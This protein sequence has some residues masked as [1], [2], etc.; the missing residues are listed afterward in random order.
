MCMTRVTLLWLTD[1]KALSRWA[2]AER[3]CDKTAGPVS[4]LCLRQNINF[5]NMNMSR[6]DPTNKYSQSEG[7]LVPFWYTETTAW[8]PLF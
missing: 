1:S 5:T 2:G 4:M 3:G 6:S 7:V 8:R